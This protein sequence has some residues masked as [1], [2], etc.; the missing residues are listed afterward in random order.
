LGH[1]TPC[2]LNLLVSSNKIVC[3][4]RRSLTQC[5]ACPLGKSFTVLLAHGG[6]IIAAAGCGGRR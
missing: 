5:Q 4:S 1:P 6:V 3:T 2:I